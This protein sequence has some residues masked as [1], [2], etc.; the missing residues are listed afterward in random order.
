MS[1]DYTN[2]LANAVDLHAMVRPKV[3]EVQSL[4]Q[5]PSARSD[6]PIDEP[7]P[8]DPT[9]KTWQGRK[10]VPSDATPLRASTGGRNPMKREI[11][12]VEPIS[13]NFEKWKVPVAA[14]TRANGMVF[15]SGMPPFDPETGEVLA[16]APFERQVELIMA[17]LKA[18]LEAAGSDLDHIL[19]CNVLC[20]SAKH[21]QAFNEIYARYFPAD[22]PAR[23]FF[24][25][26]EWTGPFDI[27]VDCVAVT[28]D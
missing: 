13:S 26:P 27:E 16:N 19:K 18:C 10:H 21:F 2:P 14:C 8:V 28:K 23:I 24:C 7:R 12:R 11:I 20:V 5:M 3:E 1:T 25:V 22:P 6:P 15:V 4:T 9:E 17:Q